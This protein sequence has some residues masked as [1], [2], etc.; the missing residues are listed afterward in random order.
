MALVWLWGVPMS[1]PV[2]CLYS[3]DDAVQFLSN[4]QFR[5]IMLMSDLAWILPAIALASA[6]VAVAVRLSRRGGTAE[7]R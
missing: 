6:A 1:N 7:S 5:Q 4:E 2:A 3:C